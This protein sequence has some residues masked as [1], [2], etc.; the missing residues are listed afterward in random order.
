[1]A[2]EQMQLEE[3][4]RPLKL[5][6]MKV[7]VN[8]STLLL[9]TWKMLL[10]ELK[11]TI[12]IMPCDVVTRWNLTFD[13]LEYALDHRKAVDKMTQDW[14]LGLRKFEMGDHEW[15]LV[16]QLRDMLKILKDA[17]LFFRAM[18]HINQVLTTTSLDH[19]Y[20]LPIRTAVSTAKKTLNQYYELT[21]RSEVYQI[22]MVLHPRHK[23][24]YFKTAHLWR[25]F[26]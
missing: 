10:E 25:Q 3:A 11:Q 24:S 20:M 23:L 5:A 6:L 21:D 2:E 13:L 15:V 7:Y 9:P 22:A 8:S 14:D 19:S 4:I 26:R 17:T 16:K 1:M 12:S 18:D